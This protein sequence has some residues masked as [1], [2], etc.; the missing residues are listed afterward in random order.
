M[1]YYRVA[2]QELKAVDLAVRVLE[3]GEVS[4]LPTDSVYAIPSDIQNKEAL[5][6]PNKVKK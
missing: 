4:A 2:G 6:L 1:Y 3:D 5:T